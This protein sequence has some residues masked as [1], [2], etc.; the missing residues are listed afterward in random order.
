MNKRNVRHSN[1]QTEFSKNKYTRSMNNRYSV[2][3]LL[4]SIVKLALFISVVI[5][6]IWYSQPKEVVITDNL[7]DAEVTMEL[8]TLLH[9]H[10]LSSNLLVVSENDIS[11]GLSDSNPGKVE[12]VKIDKNW[13]RRYLHITVYKRDALVVWNIRNSA[14]L[15]D[16][17]G[18]VIAENN[19]DRHDLPVITDESDVDIS[20]GKRVATHQFISFVVEFYSVLES[21]TDLTISKLIIRE[22]IS[23]IHINTQQ[24]ITIRIS[25]VDSLKTQV[26]NIVKVLEIARSK[27]DNPTY[28]DVRIP[29]KAYYR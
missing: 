16:K 4:P 3:P 24:G 18:I 6:I 22:S 27:S 19:V 9:S 26:D 29:H 8:N 13:F 5:I 11:R 1:R 2:Y 12:L 7:Q 20:V 17:S 10:L 25:S 21:R 28:L 15:V 23:E 14:Y